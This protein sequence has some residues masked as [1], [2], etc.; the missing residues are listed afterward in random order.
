VSANVNKKEKE[1]VSASIKEPVNKKEKEA[2]SAS[3][4]EPVKN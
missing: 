3:I 1:V 4:K 2:V